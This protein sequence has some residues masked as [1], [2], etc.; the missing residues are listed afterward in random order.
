M[1]IMRKHNPATLTTSNIS[2]LTFFDIYYDLICY[3]GCHMASIVSGS[4]T[5]T[6]CSFHPTKS[7]SKSSDTYFLYSLLHHIAQCCG[8]MTDNLFLWVSKP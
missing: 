5:D 3:S 6:E 4:V 7:S 8:L 1:I 2:V